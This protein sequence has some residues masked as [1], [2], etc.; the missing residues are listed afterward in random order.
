[1]P[2][3]VIRM[4]LPAPYQNPNPS[5]P[6][7]VGFPAMLP[8]EL[9]M[10]TAPVP[11]ICAA[12]GLSKEAFAELVNDPVFVFAY[13]EACDTLR[14]EGASFKLKA[15]LIAESA[16]K[17]AHAMMNDRDIPASVRADMAKSLV[18]WAGYEQKSGADGGSAS[19][20]MQVVINLG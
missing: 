15:Q 19:N 20:N 9:A 18:R 7:S 4:T 6:T 1:M 10:R 3:V 12:Y 17:Q 13:N 8:V 14:K 2:S 16:L 5:D 11:D